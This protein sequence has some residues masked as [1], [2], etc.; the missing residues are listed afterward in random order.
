MS[1]KLL[2]GII[3]VLLITNIASLLFLNNNE[4]KVIINNEV[5]KEVSSQEPVATI[6]NEEITYSEWMEALRAQYGQKQLKSEIDSKLVSAL[7]EEKGITIDEKVIERELSFLMSMQGVMTEEE[8]EQAADDWRQDIVYRYQLE[9]L[10]TEGV[11]VPE[12]ELQQYY[13]GYGGQYDFT[14][15]VQLSHILVENF[16]TAE[17]VAAELDQGASFDLLA[18]EYTIDE[19]TKDNGGYL[20]FIYT[21]S[22]FLPNSYNEMAEEMED[23]SYSEPFTAE[24]GVAIL[25]LHKKLPSIKFTY[26]EM[27]PYLQSELALKEMNQSLSADPLWE[28]ADIDWIYGE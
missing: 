23:H 17:K 25:Y 27:K 15:S 14:S 19:E 5:Q 8:Y 4:E 20:G 2:L 18:A 10:L 3:V 11:T 22:Q 12:E 6:G 28:N 16:E 1:K 9:Q 13:N 26:E 21:T 7:A 24:N